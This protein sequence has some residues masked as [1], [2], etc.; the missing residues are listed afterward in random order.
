M[1]SRNGGRRRLG[2][3]R[4]WRFIY[5]AFLAERQHRSCDRN[6][7]NHVWL[8]LNQFFDKSGV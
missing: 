1:R 2:R 6:G 7:K 5:V 4:P 3:N 8:E